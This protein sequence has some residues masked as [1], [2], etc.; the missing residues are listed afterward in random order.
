MS[1]KPDKTFIVD[2]PESLETHNAN[3][4]KRKNNYKRVRSIKNKSNA[5]KTI[6]NKNDAD[7]TKDII[8]PILEI[9]K[10]GTLDKEK[11]NIRE[12]MIEHKRV[13]ESEPT[14]DINNDSD[15]SSVITNSTNDD[16]TI[17][18]DNISVTSNTSTDNDSNTN[19]NTN[20]NPNM[21]S[22][23]QIEKEMKIRRA[24]DHR[25]P[26]NQPNK[27]LKLTYNE[28]NIESTLQEH[29]NYLFTNLPYFLTDF[30]NHCMK[31][32]NYNG[33][34]QHQFNRF[35]NY[36]QLYYCS[37]YALLDHDNIKIDYDST[38]NY[39][40]LTDYED[41]N[42]KERSFDEYTKNRKP[43]PGF[44]EQEMNLSSLCKYLI[45]EIY[46]FT[47]I[48][49]NVDQDDYWYITY[50]YNHGVDR[51]GTIAPFENYYLL[52]GACDYACLYWVFN[53][54]DNGEQEAKDKYLKKE[55]RHESKWFSNRKVHKAV[56][57]YLDQ[58]LNIDIS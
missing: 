9:P 14:I 37:Y 5:I 27:K 3:K 18:L 41:P 31:I 10:V 24:Y 8:I 48:T 17:N 1:S 30:V 28:A 33:L 47:Y 54:I 40:G 57:G 49:E 22:T 6:K 11:D 39:I 55:T 51:G 32:N 45:N 12:H 53:P 19:I 44:E 15:N 42:K 52:K 23:Q 38:D 13:L 58:Y 46:H 16:S 20:N 36:L 56:Q 4:T 50:P 21:I 34:T 25:R 35:R 29:I 26:L 7:V 43:I 2:G